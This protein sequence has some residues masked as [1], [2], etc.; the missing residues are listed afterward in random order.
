[1]KKLRFWDVKWLYWRP[2]AGPGDWVATL[3][4]L[5]FAELAFC[6]VTVCGPHPDLWM[7]ASLPPFYSMENE[8]LEVNLCTQVHTDSNS[9]TGFKPLFK[10][11][12]RNTKPS[13][14]SM[15]RL[16][17][18]QQIGPLSA[19]AQQPIP[20]MLTESGRKQ[21]CIN[22]ARCDSGESERML[23][24][25]IIGPLFFFLQIFQFLVVLM[26]SPKFMCW[27]L[28]LQWNS[29]ERRGLTKGD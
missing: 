19:T 24:K 20:Q 13:F 28:N 3:Q 7:Q 11:L 14:S 16:S 12:S 25:G 5:L 29:V 27:K 4:W 10:P 9:G 15:T 1:M 8:G 21:R 17:P 23:W 2:I 18:H 22:W 6:Y 26:C